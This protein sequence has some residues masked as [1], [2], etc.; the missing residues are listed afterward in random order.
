MLF[1]VFVYNLV[2]IQL[3]IGYSL[4]EV[5]YYLEAEALDEAHHGSFIILYLPVLELAFQCLFGEG[6]L[7]CD[8]F[9]QCLAY[10][11]TGLGGGYDVQPILLG[12]LRIRCHYLHLVTAMQHLPQLYI[13]AVYFG[14]DALASQFAVNVERKIEH[15][16][17]FGQFEQIAFGGKY[18]DF[19]FVQ[20][21]FELVHGFQPVAVRIL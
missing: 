21:Q 2:D 8:H 16:G 20:I 5:G 15:G 3:F 4:I 14:T 1:L 19:I 6:M 11:S 17:A 12:R 7:A 9:F 18:K 10:F 13:L